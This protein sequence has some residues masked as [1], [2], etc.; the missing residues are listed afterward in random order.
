MPYQRQ[1]KQKQPE[2]IMPPNINN[3]RIERIEGLV[4]DGFKRMEDILAGIE[5]RVR[6]LETSNARQTGI[7]DVRLQNMERCVEDHDGRIGEM[8]K[9]APAIRAMIW[10]GGFLGVSVAALIWAILIH[11]V[12]LVRP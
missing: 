9:L 2:R 11:A 5:T 8:E 7:Q 6:N 12:T 1:T 3:E 10:V 4:R